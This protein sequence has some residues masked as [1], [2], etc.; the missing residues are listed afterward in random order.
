MVLP[1]ATCHRHHSMCGDS[2]YFLLKT[3]S[4]LLYISLV[5]Y[6]PGA[7]RNKWRVLDPLELG[8]Q[9]ILNLHAGFGT[10]ALTSI[11]EA[12]L[13]SHSNIGNTKALA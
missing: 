7:H 1:V 6:L 10:E 4:Y 3:Y 9:R 8:L 5:S 12:S 13:L 11:R 2:I